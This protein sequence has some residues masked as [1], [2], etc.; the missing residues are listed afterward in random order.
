MYTSPL[1]LL[2][3]CAQIISPPHQLHVVFP[4]LFRIAKGSNHEQ[5]NTVLR[6]GKKKSAR[7]LFFPSSGEILFPPR[8]KLHTSFS[9]SSSQSSSSSSFS[10]SS[11]LH[12]ITW[13]AEYVHI[14]M[15]SEQ[16]RESARGR[17][18]EWTARVSVLLCNNYTFTVYISQNL[19]SSVAKW[20]VESLM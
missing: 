15:P 19:L 1:A 8:W 11:L 9:S 3:Y 17:H 6:N 5:P 13:C 10:S 7:N 16:E 18:R 14:T 12:E 20:I 2:L 4:S